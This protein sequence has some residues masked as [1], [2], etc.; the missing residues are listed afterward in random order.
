MIL[1]ILKNYNYSKLHNRRTPHLFVKRDCVT[2]LS[3]SCCCLYSIDYSC[4]GYLLL[5]VQ[6]IHTHCC[7]P[8]V[9]SAVDVTS[10]EVG[11][12]K[13]CVMSG[14]VAVLAGGESVLASHGRGIVNRL[15]EDWLECEHV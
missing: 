2:S 6:Y 15:C 10:G 12:E 7:P 4:W 9:T 5:T 11:R 13:L 14:I 1:R 3:G 8:A